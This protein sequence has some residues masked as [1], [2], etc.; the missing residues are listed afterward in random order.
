M[1]KLF[2]KTQGG[3]KEVHV[4]RAWQDISGAQVYLFKG[5]HY[6]YRDETPIRT[7][8][9][10]DIITNP[11]QR[12]AALAWWRRTGEKQSREYYDSKKLQAEQAAGDYRETVD[13]AE[14]DLDS[15]AYTRRSTRGGEISDPHTW[16]TWFSKRPDWWGQ[17]ATISFS[18]YRYDMVGDFTDSSGG[19]ESTGTSSGDETKIQSKK[20]NFNKKTESEKESDSKESDS[21][22]GAD[23]EKTSSGPAGSGG[24]W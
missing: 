23:P 24:K 6:G 19:K 10:F 13:T 15:L 12:N 22:G 17:A 21:A 11:Q 5:G 16:P 7:E 9:E 20:S 4:I 8:S 2:I 1:Q 18:D 3:Q 14:S